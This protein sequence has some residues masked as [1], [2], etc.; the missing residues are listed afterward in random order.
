MRHWDTVDGPTNAN[1]AYLESIAQDRKPPFDL[2]QINNK[3]GAV[4]EVTNMLP[5]AVMRHFDLPFLFIGASAEHWSTERRTAEAQKLCDALMKGLDEIAKDDSL[6]KGGSAKFSDRKRTRGEVILAAVGK[7]KEA[8]RAQNYSP[9]LSSLREA[10]MGTS[11]QRRVTEI[12]RIL[13][14]ARWSGPTS[15]DYEV[16]REIGAIEFYASRYHHEPA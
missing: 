7:F 1:L 5:S 15:R 2:E 9:S 10:A 16:Y 8:Y 4:I 14:R 12:E 3:F 13:N 11:I 6:R